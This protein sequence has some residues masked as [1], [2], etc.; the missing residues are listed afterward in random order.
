MSSN[1]RFSVV[2]VLTLSACLTS[3]MVGP[4]FHAPKRDMPAA[5]LPPTTAPT[6]Q[7]ASVPTSQPADVAVWWRSFNDPQLD[8]LIERATKSNLDLQQAES[9]IRQ[10]RAQRGVVAAGFWPQ[11]SVNAAYARQGSDGST[12]ATVSGNQVRASRGSNDLFQSGFD[13]T[14]E[15]DVFGGVRREIEA[16]TAQIHFAIEDR[17]D[18]LVTLTSEIALNYIELRGLQ[19]QIAIAHENLKVQQYGADL[20]RRRQRGGLVS[21]LRR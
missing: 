18:V 20:T 13:A 5:W 12:S 15:L 14:W 21:S 6:T 17:R 16:A 19:R 9:R 10:A 4:D 3:C 1:K 11:A 8:S 7:N 2:A